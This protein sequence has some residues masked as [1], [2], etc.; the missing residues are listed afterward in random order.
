MR[1][2]QWK[3]P[4]FLLVAGLLSLLQSGCFREIILDPRGLES[5]SGRTIIV[6]TDDG[7]NY[8]FASGQY[9]VARDS[10]QV[11]FLQ[12][13]GTK[14]KPGGSH[15]SDFNG[16]IPLEAIEKVTV[17]EPTAWV[18]VSVGTI[19]FMAGVLFTVAVLLHG[20]RFG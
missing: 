18:Y 9:A 14:F 16:G 19:G 4:S 12:G 11:G 8:E 5:F 13:N 6:W 1:S 2:R 7:W 20:M 17:S 10:N 15:Y 3:L